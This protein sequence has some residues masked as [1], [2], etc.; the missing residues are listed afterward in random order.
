MNPPLFDLAYC[1]IVP[2]LDV[3]GGKWKPLVVYHVY[4]GTQRFGDLLRK[5]P[6]ISKTMLTQQ[7]RELERD[8]LLHRQVFAEVPPHVEYTLTG[9]GL[10]L[11]PVLRAIGSWGRQLKEG[12][13]VV[14]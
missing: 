1:P 4:C 10:T 8:G 9:L 12:I 13:G 11:L 14:C 3:I 7:L 6:T 5:M 2:A